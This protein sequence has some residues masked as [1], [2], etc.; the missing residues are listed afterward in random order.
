VEN[1]ESGNIE[2]SLIIHAR[3]RSELKDILIRTV[4]YIG[5]GYNNCSEHDDSYMPY[6]YF[7]L[8]RVARDG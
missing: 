8:K 1:D 2:F 7:N 6:L 5:D 4:R 3:S